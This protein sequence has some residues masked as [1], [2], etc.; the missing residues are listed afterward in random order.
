[1]GTK[2]VKNMG[3]IWFLDGY[4]MGIWM[5]I[6]NGKNGESSWVPT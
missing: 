1:V 4:N 3:R 2:N 5:D 6:V